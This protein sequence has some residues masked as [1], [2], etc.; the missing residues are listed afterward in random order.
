MSATERQTISFL[1]GMS[2]ITI[3]TFT[4]FANSFGAL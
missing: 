1:L 2:A 4:Y 3:L